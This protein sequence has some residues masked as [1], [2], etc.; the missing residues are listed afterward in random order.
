MKLVLY[1]DQVSENR[2]V[3][4]ELQKLLGGGSDVFGYIPSCADP[5]RIHYSARQ[6]YYADI[7][8]TLSTYFELDEDFKPERLASLLDCDGIHLSGGNTYYFL[9]WIRERGIGSALVDYAE[10]GGILVGVSAGSM[11]LTPDITTAGLCGDVNDVGLRDM[12]GLGLV[13]ME[14][15]PHLDGS[16]EVSG[17]MERSAETDRPV[18]G[19]RDGE[20]IVVSGDEK[21]VVGNPVCSVKG[22]I[23]SSTASAGV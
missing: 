9:H 11:I 5:E 21:I 3:D 10:R 12:S 18:Y 23:I 19:C 16:S 7:G 17:L 13:E 1:S 2:D 4:D 8:I 6:D 15:L 20:G 14:F 22:R